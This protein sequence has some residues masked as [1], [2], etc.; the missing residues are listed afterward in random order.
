MT[1]A[2][3]RRDGVGPGPPAH[4]SYRVLLAVTVVFF[5]LA[6]LSDGARALLP[7]PGPAVFYGRYA[8]AGLL[9]LATW[10][11]APG[12]ARPLADAAPMSRW[13]VRGSYALAVIALASTAWSIAPAQTAQQAAAYLMLGAVLHGLTACRW[14]HREVAL[15]DLAAVVRPL[16]AMVALGLVGAR[17][18]LVTADAHSGRHHGVFANANTLGML[19]ALVAATSAGL[20]LHR[21]S[22]WAAGAVVVCVYAILLAQTRTAILALAAAGLWLILRRGA[23]SAVT[24][25][26][27]AA[28]AGLGVAMSG[29]APERLPG[30]AGRLAQRFSGDA[31]SGVLSGRGTTWDLTLQLW[32][33]RPV[34]GYGFRTGELV[35]AVQGPAAGYESD[36][37]GNSFLQVVLELGLLGVVPFGIL[38]FALLGVARRAPV[39]G[40][41]AGLVAGC[42]VGLCVAFTESA[43]LGTGQAFCW[44]VWLVAAAGAASGPAPPRAD[45]R[46][47]WGRPTVAPAW[48]LPADGR[49]NPESSRIARS[50]H[51]PGARGWAR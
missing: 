51:L 33:Q 30:P 14:H 10:G 27:V 17:I 42:V 25:G 39:S 50:G 16:A 44:L 24:A 5:A 1:A 36:V 48:V 3:R 45:R 21:R 43:L 2:A 8:L 38:L 6:S 26:V 35:I 19:A 22:A 32:H 20:F 28:L 34:T 49:Q 23:R 31:P 41:G 4:G 40:G 15:G 37:I 12:G 7:L 18:G 9:V 29:L 47:S 46:R 11:Q 13:I